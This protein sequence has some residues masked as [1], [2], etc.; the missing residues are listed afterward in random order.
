DQVNADCECEGTIVYDCTALQANIGD[1]CDDGN[2]DTENDVVT[3]DCECAGTPIVVF[4]CPDLEANIGDACDDQN[5]A[6]ENDQINADC[7]CEGILP[8][9]LADGGSIAFESGSATL[10]QCLETDEIGI[11]EVS[12]VDAPSDAVN[13]AWIVVDSVGN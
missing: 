5:P 9:C 13:F 12:I 3:E 7:E 4:D 6:T 8:D 1:P 11:V 2:A 10:V